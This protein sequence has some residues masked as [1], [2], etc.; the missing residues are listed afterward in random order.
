MSAAALPSVYACSVHVLSP[1]HI[2][3][4]LPRLET[5]KIVAAFAA[6]AMLART[7]AVNVASCAEL[8]AMDK[9]DLD[10]LA[11]ITISTA[12]FECEEYTRVPIRSSDMVL[13]SSVGK[14]TFTNFAL[15]IIGSVV[16]EMDVEFTG[17]KS[18][19]SGGGEV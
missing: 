19:V 3:S 2:N 14:V 16:V 9:T 10:A 1:A 12:D 13:K 6:L 18:V 15:K 11:E 4:Q 17:V 8:A 5:S 7:G